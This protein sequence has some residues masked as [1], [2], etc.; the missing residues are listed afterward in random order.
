MPMENYLYPVPMAWYKENDV[1]KYGF[2][3]TS[4]RY[5]NEYMKNI[6]IRMIQI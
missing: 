2:H 5:I 6:W 3:G 4:Y 1:R